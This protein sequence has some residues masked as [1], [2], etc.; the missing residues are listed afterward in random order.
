MRSLRRQILVPF[1]LGVTVLVA[2]VGAVATVS[3]HHG[4]SEELEARADAT[5]RA[6]T[7]WRLERQS[8][9]EQDA[10]I[11]ADQMA[12]DGPA[13]GRA[14][15]L[16]LPSRIARHD[17]VLAV[18]LRDDVTFVAQGADWARL[19]AASGLVERAR[20]GLVSGGMAVTTDGTPVLMGAVPVRL[21]EGRFGAV[22][23]GEV[24]DEQLLAQL[25]APLE[26]DVAVEATASAPPP[27]QDGRR[28]FTYR[29]QVARGSP[30]ARLVTTL[31][32]ARVRAATGQAALTALGTGGTIAALLVVLVAGLLRGAVLGPL[33]SLRRAIREAT[34]GDLDATVPL[35]GPRELREVAEGFGQMT[36][37]VAEQNARLEALAASDP[38]TGLAN[39]RRF[40]ER[41]EAA[42]DAA[43]RAAARWRW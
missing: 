35:V 7:L 1:V 27:D 12:E 32:T 9:L 34:E 5:S 22:L 19:P 33:T 4:A 17:L 43:R 15:L 20:E 36:R 28:R 40:H 41:L 23:I 25:S 2:T 14:G 13:E 29:A 8:A 31:T 18:D 21:P 24:L 3:T 38:L 16:T 26:L 6:F 10:V 39:H 42:I 37:T 11:L 30:H